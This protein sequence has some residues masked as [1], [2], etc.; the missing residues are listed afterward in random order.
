MTPPSSAAGSL[1]LG[2]GENRPVGPVE[3]A[4]LV[5]SGETGEIGCQVPLAAWNRPISSDNGRLAVPDSS[6]MGACV[7]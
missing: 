7:G 6:N 3:Q 5:R 1:Y 2:L 4:S